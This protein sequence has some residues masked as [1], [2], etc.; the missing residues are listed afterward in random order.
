MTSTTCDKAA[1]L[2]HPLWYLA[3]L[4]MSLVFLELLLVFRRHSAAPTGAILV[5]FTTAGGFLAVHVVPDW[6][7]LADG[8]PEADVRFL[9]VGHRTCGHGRG[10]VA[11]RRGAPL[12][13]RGT[14]SGHLKSWT[15]VSV[16]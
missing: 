10:C 9:L 6:G 5:G 11:W 15:R 8:Y 12:S 14:P 16:S 3:D 4:R 7:P 1:P 2:R 13:D